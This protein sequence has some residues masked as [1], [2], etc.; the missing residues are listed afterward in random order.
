MRLKLRK[1]GG[2]RCIII[3]KTFLETMEIDPNAEYIECDLDKNILSISAKKI[4]KPPEK[5]S[6]LAQIEA[7]MANRKTL[8]VST[9]YKNVKGAR[10]KDE[11]TKK[12][13]EAFKILEKQGKIVSSQGS[14]L[15]KK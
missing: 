6:F 4:D 13:K 1:I 14:Y 3:P 2:S 9:I 12:M 5:N 7:M 8:Q 15:I 10:S 11:K